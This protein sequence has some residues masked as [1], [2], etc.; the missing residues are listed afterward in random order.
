MLQISGSKSCLLVILIIISFHSIALGQFKLVTETLTITSISGKAEPGTLDEYKG[1]YFR[2]NC[3]LIYKGQDTL[4]N[5]NN[6]YYD[7]YIT[8]RFQGKSYTVKPLSWDEAFSQM[9]LSNNDSIPLAFSEN[10]FY[11]NNDLFKGDGDYSDE[12][13][14]I[15][16]T[17][18]VCLKFFDSL[19]VC[20]CDINNVKVE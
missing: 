7:F 18:S 11:W 10:I 15:L 12:L 8:Y 13:I 6:K 14:E 16:P 19:E 9:K 2:F 17:L 5:I 4:I 1:P 20:S 3:K